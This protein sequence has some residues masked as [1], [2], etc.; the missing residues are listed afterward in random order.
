MGKIMLIA[1]GKVTM[2]PSTMVFTGTRKSLQHQRMQF[3]PAVHQTQ[4]CPGWGSDLVPS[5]DPCE[6]L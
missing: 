1:M 3:Q 5:T 6:S 4:V 2:P